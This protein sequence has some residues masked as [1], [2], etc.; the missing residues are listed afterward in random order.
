MG[1]VGVPFGISSCDIYHCSGFRLLVIEVR[2]VSLFLRPRMTLLGSR[3]CWIAHCWMVVGTGM[4]CHPQRP[5]RP[6]RIAL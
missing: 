3:Q 4:K 1:F 5:C 2:I 6:G